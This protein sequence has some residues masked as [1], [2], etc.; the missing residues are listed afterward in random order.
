MAARITRSSCCLV[1]RFKPQKNFVAYTL[2]QSAGE[3]IG[4]SETGSAFI[5]AGEEGNHAFQRTVQYGG[6]F[7]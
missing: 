1:T 5:L 7:P 3:W 2:W 6:P 4:L